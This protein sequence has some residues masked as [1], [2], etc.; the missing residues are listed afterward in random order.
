MY[1]HCMI[2]LWIR[3]CDQ[4]VM[5]QILFEWLLYKLLTDVD[6]DRVLIQNK[7]LKA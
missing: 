6:S 7:F 5:D 3:A 2:L 4:D 1:A